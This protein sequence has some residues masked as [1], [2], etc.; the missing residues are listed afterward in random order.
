MQA[1]RPGT[2]EGGYSF[3]AKLLI[4]LL[5]VLCIATL[6]FMAKEGLVK[7]AMAEVTLLASSHT[8]GSYLALFLLQYIFAAVPFLP[9]VSTL[10][11]LQAYLMK[12]FW[13]SFLLAFLGGYT[14]S[15]L[16][17]A[18]TKAYLRKAVKRRLGHTLMFKVLMLEVKQNPVR[19]GV[20]FNMLFIPISIKNYLLGVSGLTFEQLCIAFLPGP[21]L[22]NIN[23]ALVG[24]QA[25]S[26]S[27]SLAHTSFSEKSTSEKL[28]LLFSCLMIAATMGFL[29]LI[30]WV[31]RKK[32]KELEAKHGG[33]DEE[34]EKITSKTTDMI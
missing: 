7:A 27:D 12:G 21:L 20:I 16:V 5:A 19:N 2:E 3:K 18:V 13:A 10:N 32:M 33:G 23:C 28:E 1:H 34:Y 29:G 24:S 11:V 8:P 6:L 22:F 26:L 14:S 31:I 30:S 4:G 25:S 9:G 15:L 17:A